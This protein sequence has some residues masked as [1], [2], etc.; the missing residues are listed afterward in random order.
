MKA[1]PSHLIVE[2]KVKLVR[3]YGWDWVIT[4][5]FGDRTDYEL[6]LIQQLFL[7]NLKN[8]TDLDHFVRKTM[9]QELAGKV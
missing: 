5:I 6:K 3:W 4:I 9:R 8:V 2:S 7:D 1:H